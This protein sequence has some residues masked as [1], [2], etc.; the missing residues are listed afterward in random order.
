MFIS[1]WKLVSLSSLDELPYIKC[2]LHTVLKL[3]PLAYGECVLISYTIMAEKCM[4]NG[5]L[6]VLVFFAPTQ[7]VKW[8]Q[9]I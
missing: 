5:V 7:D 2:P 8:S 3:T 6:T 4:C 1:L 9:S